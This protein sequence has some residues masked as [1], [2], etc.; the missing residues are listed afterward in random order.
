M[1]ELTTHPKRTVVDLSKP[2]GAPERVTR[3]FY[4]AAEWALIAEA[5][6]VQRLP[7]ARQAR[8][9]EIRKEALDLIESVSGDV[10]SRLRAVTEYFTLALN[11]A[12][13]AQEETRFLE[14]ATVVSWAAA[15]GAEY[16]RVKD[17]INGSD[18]P[19]GVTANWPPSP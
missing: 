7:R 2:E 1:S 15:V 9:Q 3:E 4:T 19:G 16:D 14:L 11:S 10:D 6:R 13:T 12:R 18:D 8:Q 17:V 5:R